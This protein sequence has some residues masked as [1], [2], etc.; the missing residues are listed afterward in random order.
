[1]KK[2]K[3]EDRPTLTPELPAEAVNVDLP[4]GASLPADYLPD[5]RLR[6]QLYR[7]LADVATEAGLDEIGAE[8]SDRFGP[9]PRAVTQLLFLFRVKLRARRAG[10]VQVAAERKQLVLT[11]GGLDET[12]LAERITR[13][14]G[15]AR[16]GKNKVW[17][18][19]AETEAEWQAELL[20]VLEILG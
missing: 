18:L 6:L 16:T 20:E 7:R 8:L 12:E 14:G 11:L 3:A 5:E 2:L 19:R 17:L 4:V 10:V 9:L 15:R 13:L 1:V